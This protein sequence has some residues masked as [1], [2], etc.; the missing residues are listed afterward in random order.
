MS[1]TSEKYSD[2]DFQRILKPDEIKY[3]KQYYGHYRCAICCRVWGSART[4][5]NAYQPCQGCKTAT[6]P[7]RMVCFII[8]QIYVSVIFLAKLTLAKREP[9]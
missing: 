8:T 3:G 1:E 2:Q 5:K 9:Y 4:Y 6:F 7:H